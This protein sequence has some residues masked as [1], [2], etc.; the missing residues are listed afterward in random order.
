VLEASKHG[1]KAAW[2]RKWNFHRRL[3]PEEYDGRVEAVL[4]NELSL[5]LGTGVFLPRNLTTSEA[6]E[7]SH[8]RHG[9]YFLP[10]AYA[11]W[12]P[13]HPS[14]PAGHSVVAG[15]G[16]TV[17]KA[18]FNGDYTLPDDQKV[19]P[20]L[21]D[22]ELLTAGETTMMDI[23]D[24]LTVRGELNKLASAL[25]R[26]RAGIHYRTDGVDGLRLGEAAAIRF[27]KTELSLPA[28]V[29]SIE[30]SFQTFD[31]GH[32]SITPCVDSA[33]GV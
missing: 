15:A 9:L 11:E 13:I 3:R 12:S 33:G 31:G 29:E 27:L 18:L 24:E 8:D 26:N 7:R 21:D 23:Y 4:D 5:P 6:L 20:T 30:L 10:Q 22:S 2:H 17:L 14:Y 1:Q 16:V 19:V 32:I 25:G 28:Q